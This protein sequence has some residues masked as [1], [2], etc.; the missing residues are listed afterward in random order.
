MTNDAI[1]QK[2]L[3]NPTDHLLKLVYAD[4]LEEAGRLE[5]SQ[6][7]R[8]IDSHGKYPLQTTLP[9][10]FMYTY[11]WYWDI[12]DL[13]HSAVVWADCRVPKKIYHAALEPIL[14]LV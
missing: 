11:D 9:N 2:I 4:W 6:A 12:E 1:F 5:E 14:I 10:K 7:W 13:A 8:W 3:D